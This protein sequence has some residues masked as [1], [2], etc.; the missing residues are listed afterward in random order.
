[1]LCSMSLDKRDHRDH[2]PL[3]TADFRK[4]QGR[5]MR[6]AGAIKAAGAKS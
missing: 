2:Q 6:S 4:H 5:L 3:E 1:M